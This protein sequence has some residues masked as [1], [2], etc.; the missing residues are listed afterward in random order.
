LTNIKNSGY[1]PKCYSISIIYQRRKIQLS[2]QLEQDEKPLA[3]RAFKKAIDALTICGD[4]G[5]SLIYSVTIASSFVIHHKGSLNADQMLGITSLIIWTLLPI[6]TLYMFGLIYLT[7]LEHKVEGGSPAFLL[8]IRQLKSR[9]VT[10][11]AIFTSIVLVM[12]AL[13]VPDFWLTAAISF[14]AAFSGLKIIYPELPQYYIVI[15]GCFTAWAFFGYLMPKGISK[16]NKLFGPITLVWFILVGTFGVLGIVSNTNCF[17]A[18]NLAYGIALLQSLPIVEVLSMFGV[19]IL[20]ITGWEAAQLDRKDYLLH[21]TGTKAVLPIQLAFGL[22]TLATLLSVLAQCA[23]VLN[24]I[25][26]SRTLIGITTDGTAI[27]ITEEMPNLFFGSLPSIVIGPMVAYAVVEVIIAATATTL[28][29]QNLFAELNGFGYWYRMP[30]IFT[31][32]ENSHE[33]YVKPICESLKWGCIALMIW[34]QTDEKLANAYGTTVVG[35]MFVGCILALNLA[36]HYVEQNSNGENKSLYKFLTRLFFLFFVIMLTP[37][38]LGGLSKVF[39]GSWITLLG[40]AT[41]FLFLNSYQWGEQKVNQTL[42][43]SKIT[44][45]ELYATYNSSC[46]N[47]IGILLTKP[48]DRLHEASDLVP[49]FLVQYARI[50]GVIPAELVSVNI[51]IDPTTATKKSQRYKLTRHEVGQHIIYNLDVVLGWADNVNIYTAL[52]YADKKFGELGETLDIIK[53]GIIISGEVE[54]QSRTRTNVIN[55]VRFWVYNLIRTNLAQPFYYWAGIKSKSN[56]VRVS[57]PTKI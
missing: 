44:L 39:E 21:E 22:N 17:Q 20:I 28:G 48:G 33:F 7:D 8:L 30:R 50:H 31:N 18:F 57:L 14:L 26:N 1:I 55:R 36:P 47:K 51:R 52:K 29:A 42:V 24:L 10:I 2:H 34:A 56:I 9:G 32:L 11:S 12:I 45:S 40:A 53:D 35:G 25:N 46:S 5:T 37:Y 23:F 27:K 3:S 4:N 43:A 41:F 54:I 6:F 49:A 19:L 16:I 13:T 38:L 15:F